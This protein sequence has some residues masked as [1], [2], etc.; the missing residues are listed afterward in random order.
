M[1][2][3]KLILINKGIAMLLKSMIFYT[4]EIDQEDYCSSKFFNF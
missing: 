3:L 2:S 1:S 4:I